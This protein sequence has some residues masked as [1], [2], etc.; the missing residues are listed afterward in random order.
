MALILARRL[1]LAL[2]TLL[3][4]TIVIFLLMNVLP[5]DP[6]SMFLSADASLEERRAVRQ[7]LGL[8]DPLP[9]RYVRWL[10]DVVH[11]DLGYSPYRRR[12]VSELIAQA[13][14]NTA[15][16][17]LSAAAV[18]LS[19]GATLGVVGAV[20]HGRWPD[21]V[22]TT[23]AL[24]GISMPSFW[25][26]IVLLI[27]F[28]AKFDLLPSSGTGTGE[29]LGS[30]LKHLVMPVASASLSTLA[31]T[32][33]VTRASMI[34]T[35][36]ADFVDMLR[37]KGLRS[38]QV[39]RHVIKNG[40][41]PVL[42]TSGLQI[43]YLLGGA[44]LIETIF[45]WPGMGTLVFTAITARDLL[46]V[47]GAILVIALTFVVLNLAFDMIQIVIDPRLRRVKM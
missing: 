36:S 46:V 23:L 44:V 9:V 40:A 26:A 16:L 8:D 39:L 45:R 31:I 11:G 14:Q 15:I 42:T 5:G 1:A 24:L 33:R 4:V 37:A 34:E 47:E 38:W 7:R 3:G 29:G 12:N 13:W 21:R 17:A 19:L 20:F 30:W 32:A 25:V 6:S 41:S 10:N 43:G 27:I 22:V 2:P 35:L 28:S 18:G